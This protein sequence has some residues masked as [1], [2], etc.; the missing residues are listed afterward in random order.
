MS[1]MHLEDFEPGQ[2]FELGSIY[3]SQEQVLDFAQQFDPQPFHIDEEAGGRSIFGGLIASGWHTC[4]LMM[5][6]L[7][8]N[9]LSR[10]ASLGSPG[11]NQIRWLLPVRPG[12]TLTASTKVLAVTSSVSK[13]DR[14]TV[15]LHYEVHNQDGKPVLAMQGISMFRRRQQGPATQPSAE[16][17]AVAI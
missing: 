11:V 3:V 9:L 13:P 17:S 12:D 8:D 2:V 1:L 15:E 14:G 7:V 5:R 6:L 10:S 4:S 16:D